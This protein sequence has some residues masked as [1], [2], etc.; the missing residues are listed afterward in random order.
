MIKINKDYSNAYSEVYE[1]LKLVPDELKSKISEEFLIYIEQSR[2]K[3]YIPDIQEPIEE[4]KLS[5]QT[6]IVL[7]IIY[8]DF[9]CSEEEREILQKADQERYDELNK[10]RE[11]IES[12]IKEQYNVDD[13]FKKR[14]LEE[15]KKEENVDLPLVVKEDKWYKKIFSLIKGIF[16]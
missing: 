1:V 15:S 16:K 10:A 7:G 6:M 4:V 2:N 8:R 14:Q 5:E 13:V 12:K 11:E 9:L 3:S